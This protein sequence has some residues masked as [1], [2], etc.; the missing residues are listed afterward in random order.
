[1]AEHIKLA[2]QGNLVA[3]DRYFLKDEKGKQVEFYYDEMCDRV[4]T[5]I[6]RGEPENLRIVWKE[7]YK[8]DLINQYFLAAGRIWTNAGTGNEQFPNCFVYGIE[9]SKESIWETLR[10]NAFTLSA[11]GGVGENFGKLRSR[12]L[13]TTKSRG[14]ASGPVS[15]IKLYDASGDTIVQGGSRRG[16]HKADLPVWHPDILEFILMKDRTTKYSRYNISVGV[17]DSFMEWVEMMYRGKKK[18]TQAFSNPVVECFEPY[19]KR[20]CNIYILG[21][22]KYPTDLTSRISFIK[23]H[24]LERK[25]TFEG[26]SLSIDVKNFSF[27]RLEDLWYLWCLNAW[28][29]GDPGITFMDAINRENPFISKEELKD[30]YQSFFNTYYIKASNPCGEEYML[31][32]EICMLAWLN[33]IKFFIGKRFFD[34]KNWKQQ[35]DWVL[36]KSIVYDAIRFLDT[37]I[38]VS[39][40]PFPENKDMAQNTRRIGLGIAA[41]ADLF[42]LMGVRYGSAKAI[43]ITEEL[44]KFIYEASV[45]ASRHLG[46]EK[47]NFPWFGMCKEKGH[48]QGEEYRRNSIL[49]AIAPVGTSSWLAGLDVPGEGVSSS[50]EPN[51]AFVSI[52]KDGITPEGRT[53]YHPLVKKWAK[54]NNKEHLLLE[55]SIDFALPDFFV[56]ANELT[57]DEHIAIH[58]AFQKHIDASISKTTNLPNSATIE[59]ISEAFIK[60]WKMGLKSFTVYRDGSKEV[61]VLN[62]IDNKEKPKVVSQQVK[63]I[64]SRPSSLKGET[65]RVRTGDGHMYVTINENGKGPYEIFIIIGKAGSEVRTSA[66]AIARL[67]SKTL[68][69]Y[70]TTEERINYLVMVIEQLTGIK[71]ERK[72][73]DNRLEEGLSVSSIPDGIGKILNHYLINSQTE[74]NISNL[75]TKEYNKEDTV[76]VTGNLMVLKKNNGLMEEKDFMSKQGCKN[77]N[78]D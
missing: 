28:E 27:I 48:Y 7:K 44:G 38:D 12:G 58:S 3:T 47:G 39:T 37:S 20:K 73:W 63:K 23:E 59:D 10:K 43:E 57:A 65:L 70:D 71:G 14:T 53:I 41:L 24:F 22:E 52:R 2:E 32:G 66:E 51:F 21:L 67:V 45:E 64:I 36:L 4:S 34:C 46:K 55:G 5:S 61:Q 74:E 31:D 26:D 78:C 8:Y 1:M 18:D 50:L 68:Q 62:H 19:L 42:I 35:I 25:I 56:T 16:A 29:C 11:G 30:P 69:S 33:L 17:Y 9:D 13:P 15:F 54:Q 60:A 76:S 49:L 6:S 40:Y 77:G 72:I 75:V